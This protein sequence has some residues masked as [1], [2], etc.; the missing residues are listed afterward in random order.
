VAVNADHHLAG[1]AAVSYRG[2]DLGGAYA[3]G[4]DLLATPLRA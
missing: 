4:R 2:D 1:L 3:L